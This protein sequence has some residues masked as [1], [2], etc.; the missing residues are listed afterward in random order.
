MSI[1][2]RNEMP[3]CCGECN[4]SLLS[5]PYQINVSLKTSLEWRAAS[6]Y[7]VNLE[8]N[9]PKKINIMKG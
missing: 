4:P 6:K 2:L 3:M 9:F 1:T 7:D 8:T 5:F